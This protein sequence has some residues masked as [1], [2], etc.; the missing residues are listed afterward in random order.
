MLKCRERS[1]DAVEVFGKDIGKE[2]SGC[3]ALGSKAGG[4]FCCAACGLTLNEKTNTARNA[5][6]R[7]L[8]P[9]NAIGKSMKTDHKNGCLDK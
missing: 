6:K 2:C 1:V 8:L 5:L 4:V 7:G 9:G 3:G